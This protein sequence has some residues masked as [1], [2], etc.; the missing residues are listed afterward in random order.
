MTLENTEYTNY[1]GKI[2]ITYLFSEMWFGFYLQM[3][4]FKPNSYFKNV[5][6]SKAQI[7]KLPGSVKLILSLGYHS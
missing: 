6:L 1:N 5:D 3:Q 2:S 4:L 7:V